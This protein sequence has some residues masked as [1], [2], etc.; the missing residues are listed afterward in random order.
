MQN[1]FLS[2]TIFTSLVAA[3]FLLSGCTESKSKAEVVEEEPKTEIKTAVEVKKE[4]AKVVYTKNEG[5]VNDIF[6]DIA[7]IGPEGNYMLIV[8]G[9]NTDPY[10]DRLKADIKNSPELSSMIKNDMSS[11]Y[12]KAHENKRMKLYH[13]GE[14][15]DVDT[16]TM[17]SIYG[18]TSTPTLIFADKKGKAVIVVPGY[19]PT[20]QFIQTI[21]FME[22]KKWEGK[23]RKNGEVYEELRNF[24]IENGIDVKKK[25]A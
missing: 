17:I 3:T 8:F 14:Y 7:K 18:V 22:S 10:S 6:R 25:K 12:I 24:Y 16:K 11:Y 5:V 23:D 21:K 2:K 13:E 15:M 9:T 4:E 20:K 19:M 1:K